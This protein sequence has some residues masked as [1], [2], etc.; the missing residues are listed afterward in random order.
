M[1]TSTMFNILLVV[2]FF[3]AAK[4]LSEQS[5]E[6]A[7]LQ[8]LQDE[9]IQDLHDEDSQELQDDDLQEPQ[10]EDPDE[11]LSEPADENAQESPCESDQELSNERAVG[12][13][14]RRR[15]IRE[16][17]GNVTVSCPF[18][19]RYRLS[20]GLRN[21]TR[22]GFYSRRRY[23]YPFGSR[24]CRC[25]AFRGYCTA[26]CTNKPVYTRIVSSLKTTAGTRR[27]YCPYGYKVMFHTDVFTIS[28]NNDKIP[29]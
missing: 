28:D 1:L 13:V 17:S 15:I 18:T 11:G 22:G 9:K 7:S 20:C 12:L 24:S 23:A 27:V 14:A 6:D 3:L 19:Y 21:L 10:D 16:V 5:L 26:W 8:E 25:Y 2:G 29:R 4:C